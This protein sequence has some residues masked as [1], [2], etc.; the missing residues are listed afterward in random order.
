MRIITKFKDYYDSAAAFGADSSIVYLR[1]EHEEEIGDVDLLIRNFEAHRPKSRYGAKYYRFRFGAVGF[2]G[3][4]YPFVVIRLNGVGYNSTNNFVGYFYDLQSLRNYIKENE[5]EKY[6][7]LD[8]HYYQVGSSFR[9]NSLSEAELRRFFDP[10]SWENWL[11]RFQELKAPIFLLIRGGRMTQLITN[12]NL[13]DVRFFQ[14]RDAFGAFQDIAG[15]ISGVLG[16]QASVP[17]EIDDKD[18]IIQKGFDNKSFRTDSPGK[19][20]FRRKY[21]Q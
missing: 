17:L 15:Y 5:V 10:K 3:N 13:S 19:K 4:I 8:P 11:S 16:N 1:R 9:E 12:P 21:K 7:H 20:R 14:V 6:S 2:C 18:L